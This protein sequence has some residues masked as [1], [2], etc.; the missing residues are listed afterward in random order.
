MLD[1]PG[2]RKVI[3]LIGVL[4]ILHGVLGSA[5]THGLRLTAPGFGHTNWANDR[6]IRSVIAVPGAILARLHN[7]DRFMKSRADGNGGLKI[8]GHEP[9]PRRVSLH[10]TPDLVNR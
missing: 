5:V 1:S 7:V 9:M 6:V 2:S 3:W 8:Q 4:L 10:V